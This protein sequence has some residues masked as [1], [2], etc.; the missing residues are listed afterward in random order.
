MPAS[1]W[2]CL[3]T[4]N[5]TEPALEVLLEG[6]GSMT[7][8]TQIG[9]G[10]SAIGLETSTRFL[11][12]ALAD[13]RELSARARVRHRAGDLLFVETEVLDADGGAIATQNA[14]FA[15]LE[16]RDRRTVEPERVLAT[17]MFT[18][19]VGSTERAQRMGDAAWRSLLGEHHALVRRELLAYRG[20]EINT[21]GDGFLARFE[22]PASAVRCAKAIRD[23]VRQMD[24]EVRAGV[25]TGECE[26][27]GND[28]AGIALHVAA[29][30]V[31]LAGANEI[32]VSQMVK[33]LA[34]GSGLRFAPR[35]S[36]TLKGI[37]GEWTLFAVEDG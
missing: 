22:S 21:A 33:D 28:L 6:T 2:F 11:R 31:A 8:L 34:A 3:S 5:V 29:R 1:P 17:L 15:I 36:H 23:G 18:D 24:L 4:R 30:I 19:I 7:V 13:G 14:S 26:I 10:Q 25:H 37:Q 35:G 32:V 9:A 16:Q 27:H 12:P 20:R